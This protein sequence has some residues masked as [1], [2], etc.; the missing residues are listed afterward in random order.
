MRASWEGCFLFPALFTH[1]GVQSCLLA[2]DACCGA[3][4]HRQSRSEPC[5]QGLTAPQWPQ[6]GHT[7]TD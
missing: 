3:R 4:W 1:P 5:L 6:E 7:G 2:P